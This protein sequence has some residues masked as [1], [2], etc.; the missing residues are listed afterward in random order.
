MPLLSAYYEP[1]IWLGAINTDKKKTTL[2]TF[3]LTHI[4][5]TNPQKLKIERGEKQERK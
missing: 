3:A 1:R 5:E 4:Q 2:Y